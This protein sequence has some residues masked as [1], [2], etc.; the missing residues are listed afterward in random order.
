VTLAEC[1]FDTGGIG[2][3]VDV[4]GPRAD[5]A[6]VQDRAWGVISALFGEGPSRIVVSIEKRQVATLLARAAEAGVPAREIGITGGSR[7]LMT[8]DG[9]P[10]I[11]VGVNEAETIW[12]TALESYFRRAVA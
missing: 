12:S 9:Q 6:A 4:R 11:D 10:T 7:I 8:V 3:T 1:A 2:L 5:S